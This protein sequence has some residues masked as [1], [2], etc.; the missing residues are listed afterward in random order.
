MSGI[1]VSMERDKVEVSFLR[2]TAPLPQILRNLAIST[3]F[4]CTRDG[5]LV[6]ECLLHIQETTAEVVNYAYTQEEDGRQMLLYVMDYCRVQGIKSVAIG[7]GNADLDTFAL[8]QRMGFR[9]VEVW[10]DH[11]LDESKVANVKHS[12]VNRDMIRFR[13]DLDETIPGY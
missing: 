9:V 1:A 4:V 13:A 11:L 8:L 6:A 5:V 2:E 12:I 3:P 10:P 7:C